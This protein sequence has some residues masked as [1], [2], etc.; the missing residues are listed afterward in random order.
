M[1]LM[2][3]RLFPRLAAVWSNTHY[4][5]ENEWRRH[6]LVCTTEHF[7]T[8]FRFALGEGLLPAKSISELVER[9]ND[10]EFIHTTLRQA[11]KETL[12]SGRTRASV[13]LE[14]LT[15]HAPEVA[16]DHI[17]PLVS[18]LFEIADELDIKSDE[19]RGMYDLAHNGLR[20]HWLLNVLVRDR[21]DLKA[22]IPMLRAAMQSAS[23]HWYCDFAE[24]CQ[25]DHQPDR[26]GRLTPDDK[27][28]VDQK[29][30]DEFI[31]RA[32]GR[33]RAAA[34]DGSIGNQRRL[35]SMLYEWI[36]L[37]PNGIKEVR[38]KVIKLL[39]NNEFVKHLGLDT[40]RIT[41]SHSMGFG[42][43][44]DLVARGTAQVNKDAIR[45]LADVKKFMACVRELLAGATDPAE[46]TFW[47]TYIEAWERP[48]VER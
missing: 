35:V 26:N 22:R 45:E 37:S 24:H 1:R 38:P 48:D 5:Y 34:K 47:T 21:L 4:T 16:E 27:R 17:G 33:I 9:A 20:I 28:Y 6:R 23:L 8:Y 29:T 13:Y 46:V 31:K 7:P 12:K 39:G 3:P 25:Q 11:L 40:F 14:E 10:R 43:T 2:L 30:A 42:G 18:A 19:G 41:W 32:L 44:G 36:R 15:V